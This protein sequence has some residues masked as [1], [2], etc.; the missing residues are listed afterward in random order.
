MKIKTRFLTQDSAQIDPIS[1]RIRGFS[2]CEFK[3]NFWHS[4]IDFSLFFERNLTFKHSLD[5]EVDLEAK[6]IKRFDDCG[7]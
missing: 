1:L 6:G 2:F 5:V 7:V 4:R 3:D